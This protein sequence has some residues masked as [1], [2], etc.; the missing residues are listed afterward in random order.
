[1]IYLCYMWYIGYILIVPGRLLTGRFPWTKIPTLTQR[2]CRSL[3]CQA[4]SP[5]R[6][7][8]P[9]PGAF[10]VC[11]HGLVPLTL[12]YLQSAWAWDITSSY[13][14]HEEMSKSLPTY[15]YT[16]H[17]M[18][19][20][21]FLFK[22]KK[23]THQQLQLGCGIPFWGWDSWN[24]SHPPPST[25]L[26]PAHPARPS[27]AVFTQGW[28]WRFFP[29]SRWFFSGQVGWNL[30]WISWKKRD[31]ALTNW[32][33]IMRIL[34]FLLSSWTEAYTMIYDYTISRFYLLVARVYHQKFQ[35]LSGYIRY[36]HK[37]I[38]REW[39]TCTCFPFFGIYPPPETNIAPENWMVSFWQSLFSGANC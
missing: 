9:Y 27:S 33:V 24:R 13:Y 7:V 19:R 14:K 15:L 11:F 34:C 30:P 22:A 31:V 35:F 39:N 36:M 29:W 1:M 12:S 28:R 18:C 38:E 32:M 6:Q 17:L 21:W 5:P 10:S 25:P 26:V 37:W 23:K 8:P 16:T 3:T 20:C 4:L 2:F